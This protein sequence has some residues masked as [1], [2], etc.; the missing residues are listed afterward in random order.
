MRNARQKTLAALL[1]VL[2]AGPAVR[3]HGHGG[4]VFG[5]S[6]GIPVYRPYYWGPGYYP[7]P[8]YYAPAPVVVAPAPVYVQPAQVAQPAPALQ[9]AP[10]VSTPAPVTRASAP[11]EQPAEYVD[12]Y[13]RQLSSPDERTRSAS[14]MQLGRSHAQR[15]VEP[16]TAVLA[17]DRSPAVREAAARALGL[18]GAPAGL[19]ALQQA[20][21]LDDDR[22]VRHSAQFA[23]EVIRSNLSRR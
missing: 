7:Y 21:Q 10:V 3:A 23:A 4:F 8:Y 16:L 13:V 20:A 12:A 17:S 1:V 19:N 9:P 22:D 11:E 15:A 6:L 2:S 18:I 14:A 5:L